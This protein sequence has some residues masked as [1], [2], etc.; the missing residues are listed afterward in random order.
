[1]NNNRETLIIPQTIIVPTESIIGASLIMIQMQWLPLI[2]NG[3]S[4]DK[5][6]FVYMKRFL[7]FV[8]S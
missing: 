5:A 4:T 1:M 7:L 3:K 8:L 2:V 6:L